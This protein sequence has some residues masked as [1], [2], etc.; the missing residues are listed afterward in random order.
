MRCML[1]GLHTPESQAV[2]TG[3]QNPFVQRPPT[4]QA[5]SLAQ[6]GAHGTGTAGRSVRYAVTNAS[7][8]AARENA[9]ASSPGTAAV[10]SSL[11]PGPGQSGKSAQTPSTHVPAWVR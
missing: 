4:P 6:D 8:V 1:A 3:Q 11:T 7:Q 10:V 2:P 5:A 9:T